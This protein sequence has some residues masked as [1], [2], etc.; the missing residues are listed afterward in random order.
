MPR[1]VLAVSLWIK[2]NEKVFRVFGVLFFL[3]T[4][5]VGVL[6]IAGRDVESVAFVLGCISSSMF[7]VVE[8]AKYVVPDRKAVRD[9][10]IDELLSFVQ[11][12]NAATD[13]KTINTEAV[14]EAALK[15]D[16]RL[17]ATIHYDERGVQTEDFQEPWANGF[18]DPKA[19]G[20]WVEVTYDRA[21]IDRRVLVS[22]DG[23]RAM[24]P[25][26]KSRA[27]LTVSKL[28]YR[29]AQLFD[30]L[31]KLDEYASR[32]GLKNDS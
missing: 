4:A 25:M 16:P 9:M 20:Y 23:G 21:L 29:L 8:V 24:L 5:A 2:S 14:S 31:S 1:P 18:A 11:S 12:S 28:S 19:K 7:G 30:S 6:W 15:E 13:W 17:R 3:F 27:D 22:V 26:P 10:G 32:A